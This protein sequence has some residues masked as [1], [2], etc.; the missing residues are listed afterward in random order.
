MKICIYFFVV[1]CS[2]LFACKREANPQP[3]STWTIGADSFSTNRVSSIHDKAGTALEIEANGSIFYYHTIGRIPESGRYSLRFH[4]TNDPNFLAI[5]FSKR[6]NSY[7]PM[8]SSSYMD[9]SRSNGI[10][11]MEMPLS[12]FRNYKDSVDVQWIKAT[13]RVRE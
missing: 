13:I 3:Y 9:I 4:P 1:L 2:L 11:T 7:D 12:R 10:V 8:D 5:G 6:I